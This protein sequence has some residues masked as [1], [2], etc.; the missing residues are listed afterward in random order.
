MTN[1]IPPHT[2]P[3]TFISR[4]RM[5][6]DGKGITTLIGFYGC[7]L[8]CK[9][10]INSFS[11]AEDT[12]RVVYSPQKLY[13]KVRIDELYFLATGGG[14]TFGGGEPLLYPDFINEFCRICGDSWNICIET[15]LAVPWENIEK[16]IDFVNTYLID[17]KDISPDIYKKYTEK[18]NNL[19][20]SNIK[21][22]SSL[23]SPDRILAR[24]PL[25][26]DFNT[27]NDREKTKK[28][29]SE[30]GITQFDLFDYITE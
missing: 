30:L 3:V 7:P 22:L 24:I 18:D 8:R 19:M 15:S 25:I 1:Q 6:T 9:Y 16:T 27:D 21:K 13:E 28:F 26:P 29:L 4:L 23:I 20:L 12:R 14:V 5:Q 11:Y 17:I 10:C 2:A